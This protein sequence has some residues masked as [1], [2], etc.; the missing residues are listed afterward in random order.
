MSEH[1]RRKYDYVG[2][3]YE[4]FAKVKL[5]YGFWG[6]VNTQ[7]EEVVE[8]KYEEVVDFSEGFA[9]VRGG[10]LDLWGLVNTEGEQVLDGEYHEIWSFYDGLALLRY[11]DQYGYVDKTGN[12]YWDMTEDEARQQMPN[13]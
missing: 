5:K 11:D 7:G 12:V 1:W 13:D 3:F 8:P 9:K 4:G 2:G 6:F 10:D